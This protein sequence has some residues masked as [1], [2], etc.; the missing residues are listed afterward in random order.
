MTQICKN[1]KHYIQHYV[2][3]GRGYMIVYC[4]HCCYPRLKHRKPDT[5]ACAHYKEKEEIPL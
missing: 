4:G 2:Q 5:P 3:H 1:C